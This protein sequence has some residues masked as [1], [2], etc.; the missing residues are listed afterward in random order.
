MGFYQDRI[1]PHLINLAMRQ[2][3]L[4]AIAHASYRPPK[5]KYSRSASAP[6]SICRSTRPTW[7]P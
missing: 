6:D 7:R 4:A 2:K 1:L 5:A 3:N